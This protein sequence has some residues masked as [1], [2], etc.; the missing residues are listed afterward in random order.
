MLTEIETKLL[1]SLYNDPSEAGSF[2]SI[3]NLYKRAKKEPGLQ[4][5][6]LK[7]VRN[8]L[9]SVAVYTVHGRRRYNFLRRQIVAYT[10]DFTW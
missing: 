5:I 7:K 3:N 4:K 6:T 8:F 10:I 2:S 1:Y 9:E